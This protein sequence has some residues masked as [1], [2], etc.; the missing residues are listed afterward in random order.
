MNILAIS[1]MCWHLSAGIFFCAVMAKILFLVNKGIVLV[2]NRFHEMPFPKAGRSSFAM[3]S[4][5][6]RNSSRAAL[7]PPFAV[8]TFRGKSKAE[9]V[10]PERAA[11]LLAEQ[12]K[13][14]QATGFQF[15]SLD[16]AVSNSGQETS[17]GTLVLTIDARDAQADSPLLAALS[18]LEVPTTVFQ[19]AAQIQDQTRRQ[20]EYWHRL[21]LTG[22]FDF[23]IQASVES[24]RQ[25]RPIDDYEGLVMSRDYLA[26]EFAITRPM[27]AFPVGSNV[28]D[29]EWE[30]MA[31]AIGA[32]CCLADRSQLVN[33][34]H[35]NFRWGR[36]LVTEEDSPRVV[37]RR[38]RRQFSQWRQIWSSI[39]QRLRTCQTNQPCV[40]IEG[41]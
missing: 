5:Q 7:Q 1:F 33:L 30:Q 22:L 8:L 18:T 14:L 38:L 32:R 36:F 20:R 13:G 11:R 21:T 40:S 25:P 12:V 6:R 23:G 31:L 26:S 41:I 37:N 2:S 10:E 4:V 39:R 27:F 19:T 29:A 16:A 9:D 35:S 24:I 15:R 17:G 34:N 28:W 3:P